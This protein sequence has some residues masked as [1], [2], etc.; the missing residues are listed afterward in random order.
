MPGIVTLRDH[1]FRP[2]HHELTPVKA[3]EDP[4]QAGTAKIYPMKEVLN[5]DLNMPRTKGCEQ[6]TQ[7]LV[8]LTLLYQCPY[9]SS[10]LW[11]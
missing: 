11:L 9:L 1:A 3:I 4:S 6:V 10:N 5:L 7:T 2:V 8:A